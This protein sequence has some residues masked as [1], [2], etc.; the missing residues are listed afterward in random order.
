MRQFGNHSDTTQG[1]AKIFKIVDFPQTQ[2]LDGLVLI[3]QSFWR[4]LGKWRR[5]NRHSLLELCS[6]ADSHCGIVWPTFW[7]HP[8]QGHCGTGSPGHKRHEV[9]WWG[10]IFLEHRQGALRHDPHRSCYWTAHRQTLPTCRLWDLRRWIQ[11]R[12]FQI[13]FIS[14]NTRGVL[15]WPIGT[16]AAKNGTMLLSVLA[17]GGL[18]R[19]WKN[20]TGSMHFVLNIC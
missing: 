7:R 5:G 20:C 12:C 16:T 8:E 6:A 9:L 11:H 4:S 14:H 2:L 3:N 15:L 17:G 1:T 18:E 13:Q 19:F 10:Y